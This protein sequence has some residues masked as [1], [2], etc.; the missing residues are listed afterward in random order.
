[1]SKLI[2]VSNT[3]LMSSDCYIDPEG[4]D[5]IVPITRGRTVTGCYVH[6]R[7]GQSVRTDSDPDDLAQKINK[8]RSEKNIGRP[9]TG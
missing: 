9:L 7:G 6:L 8:I 5:G 1:V 2:K 4:V 3:D